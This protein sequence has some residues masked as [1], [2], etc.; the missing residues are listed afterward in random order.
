MLK[1]ELIKCTNS[2]FK[3]KGEFTCF[4]QVFYSLY[5]YNSLYFFIH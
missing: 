2:E 5:L 1:K 4:L 3:E